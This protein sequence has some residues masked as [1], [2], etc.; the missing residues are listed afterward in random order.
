VPVVHPENRAAGTGEVISHSDHAH[1]TPGHLSCSDLG[2]AQTTGPNESAP[3]RTTRVP[4]PEQL[5]PGKCIQH[6]AGFREFPA[7]QP[8]A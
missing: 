2:R 1:Q 8:R 3:L 7:K 4:E 6:R 5:R